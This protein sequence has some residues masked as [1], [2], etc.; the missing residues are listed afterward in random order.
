MFVYGYHDTA[1]L[2]P[3]VWGKS[4]GETLENYS[5]VR[6]CLAGCAHR[7]KCKARFCPRHPKGGYQCAECKKMA[8]IPRNG[9]PHSRYM[10]YSCG[11]KPKPKP[12]R[13]PHVR[14]HVHRHH[15]V[16]DSWGHVTHHHHHHTREFVPMP[17]YRFQEEEQQGGDEQEVEQQQSDEEGVDVHMM[18]DTEPM[19]AEAEEVAGSSSEDDSDSDSGEAML[20]T[21]EQGPHYPFGYGYQ[22]GYTT[23]THYGHVVEVPV[24]MKARRQRVP[25]DQIEDPLAFKI[26]CNYY[27]CTKA[28][29]AAVSPVGSLNPVEPYVNIQEARTTTF[30]TVPDL[31]QDRAHTD[32]VITA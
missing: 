15:D 16:M 17:M 11:S 8:F 4:V 18:D 2:A 27:D 20:Q 28:D 21:S 26:D 7:G 12:K 24:A 22:P 6:E 3:H 31:L 30:R 9:R 13:R 19:L 29:N 10:K 32:I 25:R 14:M 23:R 5:L 1:H